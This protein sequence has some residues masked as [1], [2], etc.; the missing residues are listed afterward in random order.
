[1]AVSLLRVSA[2]S[3]TG[4]DTATAKHD[5][6]W[7]KKQES[8]EATQTHI[9]HIGETEIEQEG[10]KRREGKQRRAAE[11]GGRKRRVVAAVAELQGPAQ[12]SSVHQG[13]GAWSTGVGSNRV[14]ALKAW[15]VE[16]T[17]EERSEERKR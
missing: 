12:Q 9:C 7:S 5:S 8:A 3:K 4:Q 16:G 10:A 15:S 17:R 11:S 14:E 6:A 13:G 2:E 1:V